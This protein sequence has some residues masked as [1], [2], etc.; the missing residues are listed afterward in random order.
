VKIRALCGPLTRALVTAG[1]SRG[2]RRRPT[3]GIELFHGTGFHKTGTED[4]ALFLG[5]R[6]TFFTGGGLDRDRASRRHTEE[7]RK[8]ERKKSD[9]RRQIKPFN[10][11]LK[12]NAFCGPN[13][14]KRGV[15]ALSSILL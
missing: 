10:F 8:R 1:G 11:T 7:M 6:A 4:V 3:G 15:S 2:H 14:L 9:S 5:K 12:L 13:A